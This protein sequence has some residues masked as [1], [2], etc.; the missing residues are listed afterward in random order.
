MRW[1]GFFLKSKVLS[2]QNATEAIAGGEGERI[3]TDLKRVYQ[4]LKIL[5]QSCVLVLKMLMS[6]CY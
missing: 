2:V 1:L 5:V 3:Q 6:W 4:T